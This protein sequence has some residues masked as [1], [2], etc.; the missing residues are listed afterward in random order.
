MKYVGRY[1]I[2]G[3]LGRG[4]M[5]YVYKARLPALGRLVAL[6]TLKPAPQLLDL[7]GY[8]ELARRFTQEARL[9][10]SLDH[11]NIAGVWDYDDSG[12]TPHF[13]LE[14]ACNDLAAAIGENARSELTR[15]LDVE[16]AADYALQTLEGLERLHRAG[17]VH[18]DIKPGNLLLTPCEQVKII[19][20][21]LSLR[22]GEAQAPRPAGLR[23][24]T[25]G[26]AAPEQARDPDRVDLRADLYAT[27]VTL[28]RMFAG[29]GPDDAATDPPAWPGEEWQGFFRNALA[30]DP[31]DRF[32]SAEAMATALGSSLAAWRKRR[33]A[34]CRLAE[35]SAT[36]LSA[37][38]TAPRL[39]RRS[40]PIRTGPVAPDQAFDLDA[41]G[42][43]LQTVGRSFTALSDELV[44]D[45]ASGLLWQR[46]GSP[47]ALN[48]TQAQETVQE[49]ARNC[50][51]GQQG[52]RLPTVDELI[53]LIDAPGSP[54]RCTAALFDARQRVL[55]SADRRSHVSAWRLNAVLGYLDWQDTSCQCQVRAVCTLSE[56]TR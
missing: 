12:P 1:E 26:Y 19:D 39:R 33:E 18:R 25:P 44:V 8:Q 31:R 28:W 51:A 43:P 46:G 54:E 40:Q 2:R 35:A 55:W 41:L 53:T 45:E 42:R 38:P 27:G 34:A 17:I 50:F 20:F 15:P 47:F 14:Y 9:M 49:L 48:W 56:P 32:P 4:G 22:H 29:A 5:G 13:T 24:G 23:I 3:L 52:W 21:G 37:L 16:R 11:P 6:K 30:A 36:P 10:A 7:L